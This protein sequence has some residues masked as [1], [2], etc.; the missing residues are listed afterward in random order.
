[1]TAS[2]WPASARA[3]GTAT[4]A[5]GTVYKGSFVAGQREGQG[6]ITMP[7][8]FRYVGQW[9]AGEIDGKGI[10]TY[11]NGDV[12]EGTFRRRQAPGRRRD[13]LCHRRDR[14]RGLWDD[15]VLRE[16]APAATVGAPADAAPTDAAPTDAA[17]A[18]EAPAEATGSGN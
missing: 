4:Y 3:T 9:K 17:P 12:Y 6:E 15:G 2:G 16:A 1:M 18:G 11:P 13:A 14:G 5:D 7:D 10:A 8:G